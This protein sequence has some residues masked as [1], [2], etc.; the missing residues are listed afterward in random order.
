MKIIQATWDSGPHR[1]TRRL[2]NF[3]TRTISGLKNLR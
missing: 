1:L 2:K 3:Q